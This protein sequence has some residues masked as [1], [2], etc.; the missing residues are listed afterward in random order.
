MSKLNYSPSIA[1]LLIATLSSGRS[2][3]RFYSILSER[4][5]KHYKEESVR[6]TLSRLKERGYVDNSG[7][8]W[9]LTKAG[10]LYSRKTN[11]M[12]YFPS[13]FKK[14][15]PPT[16]II[17]FDIPESQR[18]LRNWLRN[19]IKIFGYEM[20]QQSLW[21]GPGPLPPTFLKRLEEFGIKKNIKIFPIRK[22]QN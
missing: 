19:Q 6:V 13:P 18:V 21:L 5:L 1:D 14:N 3:R 2:T 20:L 22:R 12:S 17:S 8:G 16:N 11:L 7:S 4:R 15:V 10:K 9:C